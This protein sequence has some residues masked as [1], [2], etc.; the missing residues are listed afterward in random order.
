MSN[1]ILTQIYILFPFPFKGTIFIMDPEW[2]IKNEEEGGERRWDLL[3]TNYYFR[4]TKKDPNLQTTKTR[5]L[6]GL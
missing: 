4:S 2:K 5:K 6:W 1:Y 3:N